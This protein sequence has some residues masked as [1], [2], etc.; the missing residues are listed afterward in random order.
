MQSLALVMGCHQNEFCWLARENTLQ[1]G[2]E[3]FESVVNRGDHYC[4]IVVREARFR[5]NRLRL[6]RPVAHTVNEKSDISMN[7]I[8]ASQLSIKYNN[9]VFTLRQVDELKDKASSYHKH[10]NTLAQKVVEHQK[11][12][13][14]PK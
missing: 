11:A 3:F 2:P 6:V 12:K 14:I 13:D 5:R 9:G 7:P 8:D 1:R 10:Q 4:H